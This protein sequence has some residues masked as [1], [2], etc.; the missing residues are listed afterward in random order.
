MA[1]RAQAH[2]IFIPGMSCVIR[3]RPVG[4]LLGRKLFSP[5]LEISVAF[6][7]GDLSLASS[8]STSPVA[9]DRCGQKSTDGPL[10]EKPKVE[11]L[12]MDCLRSEDLK[13]EKDGPASRTIIAG[14]TLYGF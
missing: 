5:P 11:E 6:I 14:E 8:A 2:K 4:V 9:Q 10:A 12:Q 7:E 3:E 1:T 13:E